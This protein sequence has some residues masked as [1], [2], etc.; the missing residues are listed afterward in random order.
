MTLEMIAKTMQFILAPTVLVN[1]CAVLLGGLLA[2]YAA[3]NLRL[4]GM[5][6]E[7]LERLRDVGSGHADTLTLERLSE[8]DAQLPELLQRHRLVR[9][10]LLFVYAGASCCVLSMLL[11]ATAN[12]LESRV[13]STLALLVFLTGTAL[14]LLGL[15][16]VSL[17]IRRS[18]NALEF[19]VSRVSGIET[20]QLAPARIQSS[21]G[22][23]V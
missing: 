18:H 16:V 17:E 8:I 15:L 14:A 19:E 13:V 5:S 23:Q 9:D 12:A 20:P 7:R 2:H 10:A 22:G 1:A 6:R 4:R 3:I 11:I 21:Q